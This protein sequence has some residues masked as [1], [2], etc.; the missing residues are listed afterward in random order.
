MVICQVIDKLKNKYCSCSAIFDWKGKNDGYFQLWLVSVSN[1]PASK[2]TQGWNS[3]VRPHLF[4]WII[5]CISINCW[6][7]ER[8][9]ERD[10]SCVYLIAACLSTNSDFYHLVAGEYNV[11]N[12]NIFLPQCLPSLTELL[13]DGLL[14]IPS[15]LCEYMIWRY[16]NQ[17]VKCSWRD[18]QSSSG[19]VVHMSSFS[20][21]ADA[22]VTCVSLCVCGNVKWNRASLSFTHTEV[23]T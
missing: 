9:R 17:P 1:L 19:D 12:I 14:W 3:A 7:I 15:Q 5:A 21:T 23:M 18:S 13:Y 10:D 11:A 2:Q 16:S 20:E 8:G 22:E 6:L 4:E